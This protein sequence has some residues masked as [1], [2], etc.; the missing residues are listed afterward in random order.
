MYNSIVREERINLKTECYDGGMRETRLFYVSL[1]FF[2]PK[3]SRAVNGFS[4]SS[5]SPLA[6]LTRMSF[7]FSNLA[8]ASSCKNK[9]N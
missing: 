7:S 9:K 2:P 8:S 3:I 6:R 1:A 4:P 5:T